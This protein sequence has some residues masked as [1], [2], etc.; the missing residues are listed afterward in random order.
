MI[1]QL[2]AVFFGDDVLQSF[3][4]FVAE[5]DHFAAV[6][7]HHVIM[8]LTLGQ[9]KHRVT[10]IKVMTGHQTGTLKLGE[11]TVNSR[12]TDILSSFDQC[13]INVFSTQVAGIVIFQN[14]QD[15]NPGQGYLESRFT[16]LDVLV[17][18][19][20][21]P[22]HSGGGFGYHP[23]SLQFIV[24]GFYLFMRPIILTALLGFAS[25]SACTFPGVYKL[26][27]QQGNIVT[28]EML[29]ELQPGMTQRQVIYVMGNPV[30]KNPFAENKW[31]YIYTLEKRDEVVKSYHVTL[32]FDTQGFYSHYTGEAPSDNEDA[33][34]SDAMAIP[35]AAKRNEPATE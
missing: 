20:S 8:M 28:Q 29:A 7:F 33:S 4:L 13:F 30:V 25:L 14:A 3:N 17:G 12:Q 23:A 6:D 26:N 10:A 35:D 19:S 15:L 2:I 31:D 11:N 22:F 16:E 18:H 9:L 24:T 5:F 21:L 27:V 1:N 34:Q 32:F